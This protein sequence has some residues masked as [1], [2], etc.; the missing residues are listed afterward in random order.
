MNDLERANRYHQRCGHSCC[1]TGSGVL[2]QSERK[3]AIQHL[4]ILT[5]RSEPIR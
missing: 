2:P 4:S 5:A 1:F 3:S